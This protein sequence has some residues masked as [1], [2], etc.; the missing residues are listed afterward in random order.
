MMKLI[1]RQDALK[2]NLEYYFTGRPC[3]YGHVVKRKTHNCQCTA[4]R[5]DC[6]MSEYTKV[7]EEH[8][9]EAALKFALMYNKLRAQMYRDNHKEEMR[10]YMRNYM[11]NYMK[12]EKGKAN[13]KKA[14]QKYNDKVKADEDANTDTD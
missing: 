5:T 7:L 2:Q 4:C 6:P 13:V 11:R 14:V 8:G 9:E 10:D 3:K 12:T 1:S